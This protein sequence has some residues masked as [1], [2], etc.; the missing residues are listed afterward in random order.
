MIQIQ[1]SCQGCCILR[2]SVGHQPRLLGRLYLRFFCE[3]TLRSGTRTNRFVSIATAT[4]QIQEVFLIL[5]FLWRRFW[6]LRHINWEI[7]L[8]NKMLL[9]SP[10]SDR[11]IPP[12][13]LPT[14][15][16]I[17]YSRL[18]GYFGMP[19][20]G[21]GIPNFIDINYGVLKS[22]S[23]PLGHFGVTLWSCWHRFWVSLGWLWDHFGVT[24]WSVYDHFGFMLDSFW[25]H[26][27]IIYV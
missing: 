5:F 26:F 9:E 8:L 17:E 18:T 13:L 10:V 20:L 1:L 3:T 19:G 15:P 16:I 21:K 25:D 6:R 14:T 24:L 22:L 27:G 11:H 23:I 4:K 2:D 12:F 7:G